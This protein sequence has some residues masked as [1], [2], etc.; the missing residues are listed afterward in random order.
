MDSWGHQ[1][2]EN[3]KEDHAAVEALDEAVDSLDDHLGLKLPAFCI[4]SRHAL[5][6]PAV[7]MI[8]GYASAL[9]H[10]LLLF[11]RVCT[12]SPASCGGKFLLCL[13]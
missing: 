3:L 2:T 1:H 10:S 4:F 11:G 7:G 9:R 8:A 13:S 5:I 6:H 12:L